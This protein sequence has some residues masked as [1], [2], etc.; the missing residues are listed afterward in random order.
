MDVIGAA[1]YVD[2]PETEGLDEKE[3]KRVSSGAHLFGKN[4][5]TAEQF[6]LGF[7]PF[8][9]SL[10]QIKVG[11]D[12]MA[13]SGVN[14][15]I[16]HG[17]NYIYDTESYGENGWTPWPTIGVNL[18]DK[19]TVTK[20]LSLSND[21]AARVNYLMQQGSSSADVAY[22][23]PYNGSLAE[24]DT[25]KTLDENGYAWDAINDAVIQSEETIAQDGEILANGQKEYDA[26]IVESSTLPVQ[27][28]EKLRSLA[29]SGAAVIFYGQL[30]QRQPGYA[31]GRYQ[32]EDAKTADATAKAEKAQTGYLAASAED[33]EKVLA[34]EVDPEV[35]YEKN[36]NV[37][38]ARRT[39]SD[40]GEL[41]YIRNTSSKKNQ[42]TLDMDSSYTN[43]YYLDQSSGKIYPASP[44]NGKLTFTLSASNT[45]NV[46]GE[47]R[48]MAVALLCEPKGKAIA[49]K[50]L[51]DG[52]PASFQR[53]KAASTVTLTAKKLVVSSDRLN[54]AAIGSKKQK[55]V[56]T[57]G[58]IGDWSSESFQKG[59]LRNV[60][61]DGS[62]TFTANIKKLPKK[63]HA[64]LRLG[65][66]NGAAK[67]SV[68]GK[69]AGKL[70]YAPYELDVTDYLKKGKNT[71]KI[72][73][74]PLKNNRYVN[75]EEEVYKKYEIT[76]PVSAGLVKKPKICFYK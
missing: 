2:I 50:Y 68:N 57:K 20:Y 75:A 48:S 31:G 13:T 21:Y 58:I 49:K 63:Q 43:I 74:T 8:S 52:S 44:K 22:Y 32:E 64:I 15:F 11:C 38:F 71:I 5:V 25:I 37:R 35:S 42:I 65:T 61:Q 73:V 29:E 27:T 1:K 9:T 3:L 39:L 72:T 69:A 47:N 6:T 45:V 62:Y 76:N 18:S 17:M 12:V 28:A 24:T 7:N 4:L 55:A 70:A 41:V 53:G 14:N 10:D 26:I 46:G 30:P 51:S 16:Y 40:G 33:L 67:V 19:N 60:T 66:L 59:A 34:D 23:M 36:E 54:G 56:Y